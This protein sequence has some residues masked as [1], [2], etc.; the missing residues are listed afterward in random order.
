MLC[1]YKTIQRSCSAQCIQGQP[2]HSCAAIL[3]KPLFNTDL[4]SLVMQSIKPRQ[5]LIVNGKFIGF[6]KQGMYF[7]HICFKGSYINGPACTRTEIFSEYSVAI[8]A[9]LQVDQ[10]KI[11]HSSWVVNNISSNLSFHGRRL[12][13][14]VL[15]AAAIG[16]SDEMQLAVTAAVSSSVSGVDLCEFGVLDCLL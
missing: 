1:D 2:V 16:G 13:Y 14:G 15:G 9:T 4:C 12:L 8:S 3:S 10:N 6:S 5:C 7:V 11:N